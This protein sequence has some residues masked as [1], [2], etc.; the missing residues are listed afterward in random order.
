[1]AR[2]DLLPLAALSGVLVAWDALAVPRLPPHVRLHTPVHAAAAGAVLC[3]ALLRGHTLADLGLERS[4][5]VDGLRHGGTAL[6]ASGAAYGLALLLPLGH[7]DV[8]DLPAHRLP[9]LVEH[10]LVHVPIGTVLGEEVVFRGVLHAEAERA[11]GGRPARAWTAAVFA[12]WH[13]RLAL[14]EGRRS[15][16]PGLYLAGTFA[17]TALGDVVMGW[18]RRRSGS[19]LGPAGLHLGTNALGLVAAH[20]RSRRASRGPR[21]DIR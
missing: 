5:I 15:G 12:L 20:L 13:L 4:R 10:V 2:R 11:L 8:L 14:E 19:L 21:P 1:M 3:V 6:A 16:R 9:E 18:L 17:V 7:D